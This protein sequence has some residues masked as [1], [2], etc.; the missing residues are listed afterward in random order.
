M[1]AR[2]LDLQ[3]AGRGGH[4]ARLRDTVAYHECM[5]GFIAL[6][7]VLRQ[8]LIDLRLQRRQQHAPRTLTHQRIQVQLECILFGLVRNDYSQHCGVPLFGR[9]HGRPGFNNQE[10][11][12]LSLTRRPVHNFRLYLPGARRGRSGVGTSPVVSQL[13]LWNRERPRR[14]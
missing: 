9:P 5:P 4:S 10:G 3:L 11:T 6:V 8:V 1:D 14:S 13:D 2:H 12:P 7:G